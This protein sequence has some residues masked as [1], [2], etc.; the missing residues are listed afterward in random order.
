M[1]RLNQRNQRDL[2]SR[3]GELLSSFHGQ[4]SA[5]AKARQKIWTLRLQTS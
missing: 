2:L 5:E 4:Q 1:H 3:S